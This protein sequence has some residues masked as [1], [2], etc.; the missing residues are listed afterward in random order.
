MCVLLRLCVLSLLN[1][2]CVRQASEQLAAG[3]IL[4][5]QHLE[6]TLLILSSIPIFLYTG[7]ISN[8]SHM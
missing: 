6:D 4:G 3:H 7:P 1:L 8:L 2:F 5:I